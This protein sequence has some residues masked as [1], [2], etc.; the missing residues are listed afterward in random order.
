MLSLVLLL[1]LLPP[2][3]ALPAPGGAPQEE[4]DILVYGVLQF[5][6]AL[7]ETHGTT[8][9]RLEQ[10]GRRVGRCQHL[11]GALQHQARQARQAVG[12]LRG[13][14]EGLKAEETALRL[15]TQSTA[16]AFRAMLAGRLLLAERVRE[17]ED[18]LAGLARRDPRDGGRELAALKVTCTRA[19]VLTGLGP[20]NSQL[21]MLTDPR[22]QT[23]LNPA[24]AWPAPQGER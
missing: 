22:C 9:Q 17:L 12:E 18:T 4:V 8:G 14:V 20:G 3:A 13:A 2:G 24:L 23:P 16:Q 7:H 11:L 21:Q 1:A 6:Q 19:G 5:S 10:A 15:Q